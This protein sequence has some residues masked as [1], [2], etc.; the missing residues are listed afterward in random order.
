MAEINC[1]LQLENDIEF[2]YK[3]CKFQD[4]QLKKYFELPQDATWSQPRMALN[5]ELVGAKCSL[6]NIEKDIVFIWSV[7][8]DNLGNKP[9]YEYESSSILTFDFSPSSTSFIIVY[10]GKAPVHYNVKS[11]HKICE[12]ETKGE[13]INTAIAWAFSPQGRFF[14]LATE[15]HFY[16]WDVLTSMLKIDFEEKSL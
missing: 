2:P 15:N 5:R 7:D 11:G 6:N 4:I 3:E 16:V 12:L 13:T 10:K 9:I 1:K 14:A 8:E